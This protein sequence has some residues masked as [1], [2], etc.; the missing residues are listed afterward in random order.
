MSLILQS[1]YPRTGCGGS[2][3]HNHLVNNQSLSHLSFAATM[4]FKTLFHPKSINLPNQIISCVP[5]IFR[6]SM[7]FAATIFTITT[8]SSLVFSCYDSTTLPGESTINRPIL[9]FGGP[10]RMSITICITHFMTFLLIVVCLFCV[11]KRGIFVQQKQCIDHND[12]TKNHELL[13]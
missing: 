12:Y 5:T 6:E 13:T 7:H 9:T 1:S 8:I 11:R 3:T 4:L 2:Q 10:F